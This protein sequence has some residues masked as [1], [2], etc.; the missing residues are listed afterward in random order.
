MEKVSYNTAIL[1]K[2]K[3]FDQPVAYAMDSDGNDVTS[4]QDIPLTN[5]N[6]FKSVISKPTQEELQ[7]WL[8]NTHQLWV[9]TTLWGDGI[10]F[11]CL[12]KKWINSN[13][14]KPIKTINVIH[15]STNHKEITDRGMREALK[16]IN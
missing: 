16:L 9:E 6:K 12:I 5:W 10:G 11:T 4:S 8:W 3:G 2:Q 13:N 14:V 1:A 7:D 15:P